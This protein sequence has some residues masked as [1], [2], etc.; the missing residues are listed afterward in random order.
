MFVIETYLRFYNKCRYVLKR[1]I[2]C[3]RP[4]F[5]IQHPGK[6]ASLWENQ[7]NQFVMNSNSHF[8]FSDHS[9]L[10]S[11]RRVRQ[12]PGL[13]GRRGP[14]YL[15]PDLQDRETSRAGRIRLVSE[16]VGEFPA[17]L[18]D[19][20]RVSWSSHRLKGFWP[21]EIK[22]RALFYDGRISQKCIHCIGNL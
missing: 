8:C 13:A 4:Q 20:T 15:P 21:L 9:L 10:D 1:T 6:T 2:F 14:H 7:Q 18:D 12:R 19:R 5:S 11:G 17:Q 16:C 3:N 22:C